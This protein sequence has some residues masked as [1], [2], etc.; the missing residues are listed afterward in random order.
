V[1]ES[2][3][4]QL[5]MPRLCINSRN[6]A[7]ALLLNGFTPP[8]IHARM[9]QEKVGI[10][11]RATYYLAQKYRTKGEYSIIIKSFQ[12]YYAP[13][14]VTVRNSNLMNNSVQLSATNSIPGDHCACVY[15]S[16]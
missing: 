16:Q 10:T 15:T 5:N 1:C 7:V 2:I 8:T 9:K 6:R 14:Y 13:V 11:L 4:V 3:S 12:H